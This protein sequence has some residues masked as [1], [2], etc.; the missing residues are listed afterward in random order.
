MPEGPFPDRGPDGQE[1][2]RSQ[3]QPADGN[4]PENRGSAPSGHQDSDGPPSAAL[5]DDHDAPPPGGGW[6]EVP[7]EEPAQ[8]L[9]ICLPAEQGTWPG[10]ATVPLSS[11]SR[12]V[13]CWPR[14]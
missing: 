11:R 2:D 1:P 8:G 10:S 14:W 6:D 7:A 9:Y 5:P 12:R 3:P 13:R 4:G